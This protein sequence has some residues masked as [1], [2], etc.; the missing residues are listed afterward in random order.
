MSNACCAKEPSLRSHVEEI[1]EMLSV[2]A[3]ELNDAE[4]KLYLPRPQEGCDKAN[5]PVDDSLEN[6]ILKAKGITGTVKSLSI[7]VNRRI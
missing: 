6:L 1:I 2:T 7:E 5:P 4:L 3:K